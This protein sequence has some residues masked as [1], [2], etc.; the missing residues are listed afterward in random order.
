MNV[1]CTGIWKVGEYRLIDIKLSDYRR[2]TIN[3]FKG[4]MLIDIREVSHL[5]FYAAMSGRPVN[6]NVDM[7]R[8]DQ[9]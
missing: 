5:S 9:Y 4:A 6:L 8:D 3:E 1:G 7:E 2:V